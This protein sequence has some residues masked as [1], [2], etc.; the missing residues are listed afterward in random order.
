MNV[1][2]I[3]RIAQIAAGLILTAA[4]VSG[5]T[6]PSHAPPVPDIAQGVI[7]KNDL[8]RYAKESAWQATERK[9]F[10]ELFT[11]QH[12]QWLVAPAQVQKQGFD[13]AERSM[14]SAM[15]VRALADAGAGVPDSYLI[16][17]ALGEGRRTLGLET[18]DSLAKR[19]GATNVVLPYV[20]HDESEQLTL[21][22]VVYR[23]LDPNESILEQPPTYLTWS[24][25]KLSDDIAPTVAVANLLPEIL[26]NL[27][28][29]ARTPD[30]RPT[31]ARPF[32]LPSSPEQLLAPAGAVDPI[33]DAARFAVLGSIA[34]PGTRGAERLFE[35]AVLAAS[36]GADTSEQAFLR[37]YA[38]FRLG[39]RQAAMHALLG[40]TS[41]AATAL[42]A[43][44]N[45]NLT[46]TQELVQRTSGYQRLILEIE[47]HDLARQYG[48]DEAKSLPPFLATLVTHSES[49]KLLINIRWNYLKPWSNQDNVGLKRLL[50][51]IYP[52]PGHSLEDLVAAHRETPGQDLTWYDIQLSVQQHIRGLMVSEHSAL[53]CL[54]LP[55][56][57]NPWD[58]LSVIASWSEERLIRA[59]DTELSL[60]GLPADAGSMLAALEPF[61]AG[62]PEFEVLR[63]RVYRAL[64]SN[65]PDMQ[66]TAYLEDMREHALKGL[67]AA[68]GQTPEAIEAIGILMPELSAHS[69]AVAYGRDYPLN[70]YWLS[71]DSVIDQQERLSL[72]RRAVANTQTGVGYVDLMLLDGGDSV[73]AEAAAALRGRF[74][75][76]PDLDG[77]RE[78]L[79]P[80]NAEPA[81]MLARLRA[82]VRAAPDVWENRQALGNFLAGE[83]DYG[84][85][86][87]AFADFPGFAAKAPSEPVDLSNKA[88]EAGHMLYW[89][90]AVREA[91]QMYRI[92]T[93]Y[94][95]G[96]EAE[97]ISAMHLCLIDGDLQGALAQAYRRAQ[98]YQNG[99]SYGTYLSL[100]HIL[101]RSQEA[102]RAFDL[103]ID[104]PLGPGPWESAVVGLRMQAT[105]PADLDRWLSRPEIRRAESRGIP[106]PARF[107]L[108]WNSTD[109]QSAADLP[110]RI[111]TLAHEPRG[112][113]EGGGRVALYPSLESGQRVLVI[114]SDFRASE[115]PIVK[116]QTPVD[117]DLFLFAQAL[118]PLQR[119]D[120]IGAASRFDQ[121]AARY[122]IEKYVTGA[123]AT[124]VLPD[125]A[126]ASAKAGDPL[127]LEA[128]IAALPENSQIFETFLARAYFQ[129][130]THQDNTAALQSLQKAFRWMDHYTGRTPSTE[131]QYA[132]A[133][134]R[135]YR[136][137]REPRFRD[138]A[139]TWAH[140]LQTLEPWAAWAYAIEAELNGDAESRRSALVR[141]LFLDPLSPRLK[142]IPAAELEQ[143]KSRLRD[144]NPFLPQKSA[145]PP[146]V[147]TSIQSSQSAKVAR[148]E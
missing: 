30:Q 36:G 95:V 124:Y 17:R 127:K 118:L 122:P 82:K 59:I 92:A 29:A 138:A 97:M 116:D 93:R 56:R 96:S 3:R 64:A 132:D 50:D 83:G 134:E 68:G 12:F 14:M 47:L 81:A 21:T 18:I 61:Y 130:L 49:W 111:R 99:M 78:K 51:R 71:N 101:G 32:D 140:T 5:H 98:R 10:S 8:A 42:T 121:I 41:P 40:R 37:A 23:K 137:T 84:G 90:G 117:S 104:Q 113:T 112:A 146:K 34:P 102:W 125:F 58:L 39:L 54:R 19:V 120:F 57:P 106:W 48:H 55:E 27:G 52:V 22:L 89:Q 74:L 79:T 109:R 66:R 144:G 45:G 115:R 63:A 6:A 43:I 1:Q 87:H 129:A 119:Q 76:N 16:D 143:A 15:L 75:G 35:R 31:P 135:L 88:E 114:R 103:L 60:R 126:Y 133:A 13:R 2:T 77:I 80:Q 20:G 33:A 100:L 85:A 9:A 73:K 11:D 62:L 25:V 94:D 148:V 91:Q 131:Y 72:A 53:C 139:V 123:D 142:A 70:P 38:L 67:L 86:L 7:F 44:L 147:N 105:T 69:I 26:E 28:V 107:L 136:E 145:V 128:F 46:G 4:S 110:D 24:G 108:V 141:A 65:A